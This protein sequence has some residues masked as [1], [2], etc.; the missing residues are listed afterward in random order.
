[1]PDRFQDLPAGWKT[2]NDWC[3]SR[4]LC[5]GHRIP[6]FYRD[7]CGEMTVSKTDVAHLPPGSAAARISIRR[8]E[9]VLIPARLVLSPLCGRSPRS[10]GRQDQGSWSTSLPD[11]TLVTATI[12]SSS[13]VARMIFSGGAHGRDRSRRFISIVWCATRRPQDVQVASGK[14]H[15]PARGHRPVRRRRAALHRTGN[16]PETICFSDEMYRCPATS[17]TRSGMHPALSRDEPDHRAEGQGSRALSDSLSR[18]SDYQ[19]STRW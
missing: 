19:S 11:L 10:A 14:R 8:R 5:R 1:M 6:A 18:T 9:H 3:I 13:G 7:D 2:Y 12:S 4:Q 15:R 17:A 16:S